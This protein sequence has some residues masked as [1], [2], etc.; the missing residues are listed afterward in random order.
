VIES[1][2]AFARRLDERIGRAVTLRFFV[3]LLVALV[4]VGAALR[5]LWPVAQ[6]MATTSLW[7]DELYSVLRFSSQGPWTVLT[8]YHVANNHIFFNLVN[9]L[10]PHSDAVTPL[11]ARGWSFVATLGA[12]VLPL[13]HFARRRQLVEGALAF[14]SIAM[15]E[16]V[17]DLT[18]QAR[19]YGFLCF[20]T[21]ALSLAVVRYMETSA[22]R[23][24]YIIAAAGILGS[25]SIPTFIIFAGIALLLLW[26]HGR[27][28]AEFYCGLGTALVTVLLYAPVATQLLAEMRSYAANW[29]ESYAH[30]SALHE[31][32]DSYLWNQLPEWGVLALAIATLAGPSRS[33]ADQTL[34][35][36]RMLSLAAWL[37]LTVFMIQRTPA[38]RTT[39]F[40]VLPIAFA[41]ILT[42]SALLRRAG[43]AIKMAAQLAAALLV[44][45]ILAPRIDAYAFTPI[46]TWMEVAHFVDANVPAGTPVYAPFRGHYLGAYLSPRHKIAA[47]LDEQA[48]V[49]GKVVVVDADFRPGHDFDG[50]AYD[51]RA[52]SASFPQRRGHAQTLWWV[53]SAD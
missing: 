34:R 26:A 47:S 13:W 48:F 8:D 46:E 17:L 45:W 3:E 6:A 24:L 23:E 41:L 27:T 39:F 44:V 21:V 15:N 18:L 40:A 36:A 28:R 20:S 43:H 22:R 37:T 11:R 7:N 50:R 51:E 16:G 52:R 33:H 9:A 25:W 2:A 19:G 31:T 12:M 35:S 29:G 49:E 42:G 38:V 5:W 53:P 30:L 14:G 4:I 1:I 10:T 32:F